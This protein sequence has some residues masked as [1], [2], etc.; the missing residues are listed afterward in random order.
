MLKF[1]AAIPG[2]I[3]GI[4]TIL[5]IFTKYFPPKSEGE[6]AVDK[7]KDKIVKVREVQLSTNRIIKEAKLGK[8]K[9]LDNLINRPR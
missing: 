3:A 4:K 8:T 9:A 1:L 2:I 6:R 5:V 7:F